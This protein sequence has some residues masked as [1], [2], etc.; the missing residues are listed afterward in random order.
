VIWLALLVVLYLVLGLVERPPR[1][2]GIA[3]ALRF[4]DPAAPTGH[5]DSA[6]EEVRLM[7]GA[8]QRDPGDESDQVAEGLG[9]VRPRPV[10]YRRDTSPVVPH[11]SFDPSAQNA[12]TELE[13]EAH[14]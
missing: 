8:E 9:I 3:P 2:R 10:R 13:R 4:D 7:P 1:R 14:S 11:W 12:L 6:P 5:F